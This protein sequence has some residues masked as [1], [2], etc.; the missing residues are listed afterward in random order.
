MF[1]VF[2]VSQFIDTRQLSLCLQRSFYRAD[3]CTSSR[4]LA[5]GAVKICTVREGLKTGTF[6]HCYPLISTPGRH[7]GCPRVFDGSGQEFAHAWHLGEIHF[8]DDEHFTPLSS[9][10]G[11]SLL[12]VRGSGC[13]GGKAKHTS[14]S[15]E[16]LLFLRVCTAF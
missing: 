6:I 13:S 11:I 4:K 12:K 3:S 5:P 14:P 2:I 7:L 15:S 10:T 16:T 9:D 1:L 8:D